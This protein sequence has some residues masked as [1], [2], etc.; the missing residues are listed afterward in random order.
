[1]L[2]RKT[3]FFF[4]YLLMCFFSHTGFSRIVYVGDEI[5]T[6]T[7]SYGGATIVR[8]PITVKTISQAS[9]FVIGPADDQQPNYALLSITP[10]FSHGEDKVTFLLSDGSVINTELVGNECVPDP[11]CCIEFPNNARYRYPS[12]ILTAILDLAVL[13]F[14][15]LLYRR[16][17]PDGVVAWTWFALYGVTRSVAEIWRQTDLAIGPFTGGQL[18][19]LPMIAIGLVLAWLAYRAHIRTDERLA[20]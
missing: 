17:P 12:Q 1:M 19:A 5:E 6:I 7:L 3:A 11:P 4:G 14:I 20:T 15:Y 9:R 2:N 18:L 8:F 13:P 16:R 10:R